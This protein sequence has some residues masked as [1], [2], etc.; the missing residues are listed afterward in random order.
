MTSDL[1]LPA[2]AKLNLFLH[3]TGRRPDGY[4]SLQ[5]L[6]QF[7]DYGDELVFSAHD[8]LELVSDIPGLKSDDNLIMK[9][10]RLLQEKTGSSAGVRIQLNKRLPMGGGL[11]G[12]SS[13]AATTLVGLNY[14][15]NLR[16]SEDELA[17][18]GLQLGA[19][20]PVFVRGRAAF[21]EG[22]GEI[23][24]PVEP[25]EH[26]YLVLAPDCHV[27]TAK[28]FAH[29]ELTRDTPVITVCAAL[30]TLHGSDT[31]TQCRNDFEPLVRG[32]YPEVDKWLTLLDN[33]GNSSAGQ[34]A[35]SGSGACVFAP[36]ISREQAEATK[37]LIGSDVNGFVARGVN[38]SPLQDRLSR[39]ARYADNARI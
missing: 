33:A 38:R 24:T 36:Y 26:W 12:G 25:E 11:G 27:N 28:M 6:F 31:T 29:E 14:L 1:T 23:L 10:A 7:V 37:T 13:D 19:D 3:I 34:A 39:L 9:A 2:P 30:D 16:L 4:H 32:L 22:V 18:L 15:W 21:A 5:T 20:V 8:R 17:E 35:M